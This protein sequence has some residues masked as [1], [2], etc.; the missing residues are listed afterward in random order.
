MARRIDLQDVVLKETTHA[1]L[2][3]DCYPEDLETSGR[4][5]EHFDQ[6]LAGIRVPADYVR[7][8]ERW[9][10]ALR[11]LPDTSFAR[12]QVVGRLIVGL[13]AEA[14][15]EASVTLHRTYGVPY[16]PGSALKGLT[17]A[18]AHRKVEHPDWRKPGPDRKI[19]ESHRVLFGDQE[20]SG[21]V[22][23][24]DALW[25][26]DGTR[27]PLDPDVLTVH[28]P[29]YYGGESA[30][31]ADWD[32][33][34]PVPFVSAHGSYL[35][36][37]TGP[38]AWTEA[39]FHILQEALA[40]DGLGAK[41]A[42]GYGRFKVETEKP[43]EPEPPTPEPPPARRFEAGPRKILVEVVEVRESNQYI[44]RA[45]GS[46]DTFQFVGRGVGWAVGEKV[47]VKVTQVDKDGRI[48]KAVV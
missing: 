9:K 25:I 45:E 6:T 40:K 20:S 34:T 12:A 41:T 4:K 44:L 17:A 31:P 30:P 32:S 13:G 15:L 19:G 42:A 2:W 39:A 3:L 8:F 46:T 36:A 38:P 37:L 47:K 21:Y 33:P 48:K 27:L 24:H 10:A 7:F 29:D 14:V 18:A 26:P 11:T 23:F 35:L 1:G 43:E 16:L 28:H 22:I 5:Q